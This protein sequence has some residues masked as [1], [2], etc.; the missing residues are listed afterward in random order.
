MKLII[1][2]IFFKWRFWCVMEHLSSEE[3][4]Q[5]TGCGHLTRGSRE[6]RGLEAKYTCLL[7]P[8][9]SDLCQGST[10]FSDPIKRAAHVLSCLTHA[11]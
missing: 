6:D 9:E 1:N 5:S 8:F 11:V 2:K 4:R 3:G 7:T 10:T